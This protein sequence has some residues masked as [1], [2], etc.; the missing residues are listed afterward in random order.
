M[1]ARS[2]L[3]CL[4]A[5]AIVVSTFCESRA[6]TASDPVAFIDGL[7]GQTLKTLAERLPAPERERR[8]KA[9]L[10]E[11][12]DMARIARFVLARYWNSASDQEK[13][14][15]QG[16]LEDYLVRSYSSRFARYSG[17]TVKVIRSRPAGETLTL[18]SSQIISPSGAPPVSVD[19]WVTRTGNDFRITDVNVDGVSLALTHRQEF[20]AVIEQQGGGVAALNRVL[21]E[22]LAST[23]PTA[24]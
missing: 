24:Q 5:V 17:E 8:F 18:V 3:S 15:F 16:L 14:E 13:R 10:L 6:A 7:A 9:I 4:V 20:V 23:A 21:R 1:T 11:N 12:F 19:W 2:V 22:K